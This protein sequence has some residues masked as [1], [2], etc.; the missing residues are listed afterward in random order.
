MRKLRMSPWLGLLALV[1]LAIA[2]CGGGAK[3]GGTLQV[4]SQG[5]V[6]SLDPGYHY[7]QYDTQ[8]LDETMHRSLYGW[9]PDERTPTPDFAASMPTISDGGKTITV[10]LKSGIR[11][12]PPVNR[13][14]TS[15]DAKYAL[16][17]DF[18]PSVGNQY[19]SVYYSDIV[20][21]D[22]YAAGKAKDVSG[23]TTPD[24]HTLVIKTKKPVGVLT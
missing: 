21:S 3:K 7:Y 6:D 1:A 22:A 13:E 17:R 5:D 9:K 23:I 16:E 8:A 20:G 4:L 11:F 10:K 24:P 12:S 15:A 14:A 18:L 19:A 2:G